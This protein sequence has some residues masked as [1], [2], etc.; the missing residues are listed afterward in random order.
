MP[1]PYGASPNA[2]YPTYVAP[3]PQSFNPYATLPYPTSKLST[4]HV[5]MDFVD[6]IEK[7]KFNFLQMHTIIKTFRKGQMFKIMALIQE[8]MLNSNN[9]HHKAIHIQAIHNHQIGNN[10]KE[11]IPDEFIHGASYDMPQS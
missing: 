5:Q 3:M 2:P 8:P 1:I 6:L 4:F 9:H 7:K 11:N 10:N